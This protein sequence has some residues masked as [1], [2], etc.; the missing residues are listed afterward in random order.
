MC[1]EET[2][3]KFVEGNQKSIE[4]FEECCDMMHKME[5]NLYPKTCFVI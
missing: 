4:A 1:N 3:A 2:R 5:V